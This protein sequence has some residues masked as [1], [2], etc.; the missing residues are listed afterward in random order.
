M[1]AVPGKIETNLRSENACESAPSSAR[2]SQAV[3]EG[4]LPMSA[5]SLCSPATD[6]YEIV[7]VSDTIMAR[8]LLA[9]AVQRVADGIL[10]VLTL[11]EPTSC[12]A[13]A[14][15]VGAESGR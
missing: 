9:P 11:T 2:E 13:R 1:D 12:F 10:H 8:A 15:A 4:P 7:A 3:T 5:L 14:L 6:S